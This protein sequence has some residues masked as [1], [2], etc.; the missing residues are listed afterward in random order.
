MLKL[1]SKQMKRI[2]GEFLSKYNCEKI[3]SYMSKMFTNNVIAKH[4]I[5]M[6]GDMNFT[7]ITGGQLIHLICLYG[8]LELIK[9]VFENNNNIDLNTENKNYFK[10]IHIITKNK[11]DDIIEYFLNAN[12]NLDVNVK[13]GKNEYPIIWVLQRKCNIRIIEKMIQM[14]VDLNVKTNNQNKPIHYACGYSTI[15]IVNLIVFA[16]PDSNNINSINTQGMRP[17]DLAILNNTNDVIE[18]LLEMPNIDVTESLNNSIIK[19]NKIITKKLLRMHALIDF[20]NQDSD[21]SPIHSAITCG[22]DDEII[23]ELISMDVDLTV[24]NANGNTPLQLASLCSS[25]IV[26][27][28][29]LK[30]KQKINVDSN[31]LIKLLYNKNVGLETIKL[32]IERSSNQTQVINVPNGNNSPLHVAC[33][34]RDF[35]T[36]KYLIDIGCNIDA[37]DE[38]GASPMYY[39]CMYSTSDVLQY[40]ISKGANIRNIIKN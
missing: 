20:K 38:F 27:E 14:K 7:I 18:Y 8:D 31:S 22:T 25:Q 13:T 39:V 9:Y 6:L 36:I 24:K 17:I 2:F 5:D 40:F 26:I 1:G 28:S 3:E 4:I 21:D 10:P 33:K 16:N 29:I 23:L 34:T 19:N 35:N 32:L 11:S 15:D 37:I 30:S 12:P